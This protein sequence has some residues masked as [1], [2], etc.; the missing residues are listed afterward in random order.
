MNLFNIDNDIDYLIAQAGKEIVI[1]GKTATG[2]IGSMSDNKVY[3]DKKIITRSA[4]DRGNIIDYSNGRYLV[5]SEINDMRF[6]TYFKGVMRRCNYNIKFNFGGD[7]KEFPAIIETQVLD[8][9]TGKFISVPSGK[10]IVTMQD[11]TETQKIKLQDKFIKMGSAWQIQGIDK[12][13]VGLLIL[14]CDITSFS[15]ADDQE[16]EVINGLTLHNYSIS[17]T[18]GTTANITKGNTLQLNVIVK[19]DST[20][21]INPS[22]TYQSSDTNIITID[23]MG[24]ITGVLEGSALITVTF[25]DDPSKTATITINVEAITETP[26]YSITITGNA[27]MDM[28]VTGTYTAKF[29]N[30]GVEVTDKTGLWSINNTA[31]ANIQSQTGNSC[32]VKSSDLSDSTFI[33]KCTLSD[34]SSVFAEKSIYIKGFW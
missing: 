31:F 6:D 30:N 5:I 24:L 22:L 32:V 8:I 10:I 29:F 19:D 9:D 21:I 34:D 25:V 4:I 33:L 1:N 12:S 16:N 18:N 26:R 17:I 20:E 14:H 3:D 13:K 7:I 23:N 11:N 15:S 2:I 27:E 28:G